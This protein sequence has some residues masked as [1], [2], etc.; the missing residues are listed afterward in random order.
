MLTLLVVSSYAMILPMKMLRITLV[1][2]SGLVGQELQK[3]LDDCTIPLTTKVIDRDEVLDFKDQDVIF[4]CTASDVSRKVIPEALQSGALVID[5]S[6]HL[7]DD[8]EVP[9]IVPELNSSVIGAD[10]RLIANPNCVVNILLAAIGPLHQTFELQSMTLAT[11]QAASGAGKRGLE[12]LETGQSAPFKMPLKNNLFCHES[13]LDEQGYC[14][15]EAK[16]VEECQKILQLPDLDIAVRSVRVPI[17]RCHS[18]ALFATF[19]KPISPS[20]ATAIL[21]NTKGIKLTN[22]ANPLQA[23]NQHEVYVSSIRQRPN[24]QHTLEMF[25]VGD[26]LLKGAA[27]NALDILIHHNLIIQP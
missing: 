22:E 2:G 4:L 20:E 13:T 8:P 21:K 26:Q 27:L 19:N 15:E 24:Q 7:R 10:T 6:S 18:I 23:S 25:I 1:G 12:A 5:M 11:Y 14:D 9:L 3:L 16:I 17:Q